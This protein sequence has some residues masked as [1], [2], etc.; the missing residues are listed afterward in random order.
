MKNDY[1]LMLSEKTLHHK[2]CFVVRTRVALVAF[3][4]R[5]IVGLK[6]DAH[7]T[8]PDATSALVN[9]LKAEFENSTESIS[10]SAPNGSVNHFVQIAPEI[11]VAI[12]SGDTG[13]I[14]QR[15]ADAALS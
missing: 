12:D 7:V 5:W 15:L 10:F 3:I 2:C 13:H 9:T 14:Y 11:L 8:S 6:S 4:H 1:F